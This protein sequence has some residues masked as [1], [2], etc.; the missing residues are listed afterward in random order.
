MND[1]PEREG[2][3]TPEDIEALMPEPLRKIYAQEWEFIIRRVETYRKRSQSYIQELLTWI[4]PYGLDGPFEENEIGFQAALS[5]VN[6]EGRVQAVIGNVEA[7]LGF[8]LDDETKA[9]IR[10][11]VLHMYSRPTGPV[12]SDC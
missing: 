11:D 8:S 10:A 1:T 4:L 2:I 5:D 6:T 12:D 3:L 9:G 7:E